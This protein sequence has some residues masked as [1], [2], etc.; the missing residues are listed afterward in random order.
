MKNGFGVQSIASRSAMLQNIGPAFNFVISQR[1]F[2]Q[3][4]FCFV[5]VGLARNF[6]EET[7]ALHLSNGKP[8]QTFRQWFQRKLVQF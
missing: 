2:L 4:I 1:T 6:F 7:T 5:N 3:T 8:L